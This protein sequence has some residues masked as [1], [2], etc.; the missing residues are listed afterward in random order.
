MHTGLHYRLSLR[1]HH[2]PAERREGEWDINSCERRDGYQR[3]AVKW[4][5]REEM[6]P[7][8][9]HP[10]ELGAYGCTCF[11]QYLP[12]CS[13]SVPFDLAL[14][15]FL[16][17]CD[18]YRITCFP[19]ALPQWRVVMIFLIMH[20]IKETAFHCFHIW[21]PVGTSSNRTSLKK[22]SVFLCLC[23]Y[24]TAVVSRL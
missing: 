23:V 15:H 7:E 16:S 4:L 17:L 3:P 2:T 24:S 6:R 19:L 5:A 9:R 12:L 21:H 10:F 20:M 13:R 8:M 14:S 1:L 18:T 22:F 11:A